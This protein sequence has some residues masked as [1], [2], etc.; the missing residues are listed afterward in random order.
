MQGPLDGRYWTNPDILRGAS[1]VPNQQHDWL[2]APLD[3]SLL[4]KHKVRG[5]AK[6]HR[7]GTPITPN[8]ETGMI[9]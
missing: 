1:A 7:L 4:S 5:S 3:P 6:P 9:Q 2:E 8:S